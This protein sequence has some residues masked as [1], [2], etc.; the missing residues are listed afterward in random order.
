M[1]VC[2]CVCDTSEETLNFYHFS[3]LFRLRFNCFFPHVAK[4]FSFQFITYQ[5]RRGTG[6]DLPIQS[7]EAMAYRWMS[8]LINHLY[9][10]FEHSYRLSSEPAWRNFHLDLVVVFWD[11]VSSWSLWRSCSNQVCFPWWLRQGAMDPWGGNPWRENVDRSTFE[12]T[13]LISNSFK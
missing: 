13:Y 8:G 11:S 6:A 9:L 1:Y 2:L 10:Q 12:F 3:I 4:D 5:N 7:N